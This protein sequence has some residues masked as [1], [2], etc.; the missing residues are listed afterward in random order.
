MNHLEMIP[1]LEARAKAVS[2]F[3][4][5]VRTSIDED[6]DGKIV[7]SVRYGEENEY[8]DE[9]WI[10]FGAFPVEPDDAGMDNSDGMVSQWV[11][12]RV[13]EGEVN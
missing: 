6:G 5:D 8:T 2:D 9:P 12:W 7:L 13:Y 1:A 11:E 4:F 3:S 10:A